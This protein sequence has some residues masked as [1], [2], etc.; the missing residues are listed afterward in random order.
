MPFVRLVFSG[1]ALA[2][3]GALLLLAAAAYWTWKSDGTRLHVKP[4]WWRAAVAL[5]SL[6]FALGAVWQLVGYAL[7]GAATWPR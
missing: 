6:S 4:G 1:W 7:I 5:G 2:F 3:L